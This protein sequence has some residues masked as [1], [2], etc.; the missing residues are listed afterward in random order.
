LKW[1]LRGVNRG[2]YGGKEPKIRRMRVFGR[3]RNILSEKSL[4]LLIYFYRER[5]KASTIFGEGLDFEIFLC[6][7]DF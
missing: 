1:R 6:E 4:I 3:E 2:K 5:F 7:L